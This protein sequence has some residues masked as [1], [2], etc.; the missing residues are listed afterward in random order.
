MITGKSIKG[1]TFKLHFIMYPLY[2]DVGVFY[3]EC[4]FGR[5]VHGVAAKAQSIASPYS[6]QSGNGRPA[7]RL[8]ATGAQAIV[9]GNK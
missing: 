6:A 1:R 2:T 7:G 5:M 9:R 3:T 8:S 4:Y